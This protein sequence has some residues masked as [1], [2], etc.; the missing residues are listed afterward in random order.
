M[1]ISGDF[2]KGV[3]K[4]KDSSTGIGK[5]EGTTDKYRTGDVSNSCLSFFFSISLFIF[6]EPSAKVFYTEK[7]YEMF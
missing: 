4:V 6:L 5:L 1:R 7:L 2:R 3:R